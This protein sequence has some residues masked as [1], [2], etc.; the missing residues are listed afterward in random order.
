MPRRL[1]VV[2]CVF[3]LLGAAALTES[4][5]H[6][7]RGDGV[8]VKAGVLMLPIGL[9]LLTRKSFA[10]LWATYLIVLNAVLAVAGSVFVAVDRPS[11]A[12]FSLLGADLVGVPA[13]GA[14]AF[15]LLV[16]AV[17]CVLLVRMLY[18][19]PVSLVFTSADSRGSEA[20]GNPGGSD[21]SGQPA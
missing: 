16:V 10:R 13:V 9:G 14:I 17:G 5:A 12:R 1:L 20:G 18:T 19:P 11:S 15:M 4:V 21:G 2:A 8:I 7:L 3:C 6:L